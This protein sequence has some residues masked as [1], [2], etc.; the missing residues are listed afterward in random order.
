M[1]PCT[2]KEGGE[3]SGVTGPKTGGAKVTREEMR[4][5]GEGGGGLFSRDR[6]RYRRH[7]RGDTR[8]LLERDSCQSCVVPCIAARPPTTTTT[9]HSSELQAENQV[10]YS[11]LRDK[12]PAGV[13]IKTIYRNYQRT[14]F[15]EFDRIRPIPLFFSSRRWRR[16]RYSPSLRPASSSLFL[17]LI[18]SLT[19]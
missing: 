17:S 16:E 12:V 5:G 6:T 19:H 13:R 4:A 14:R 9:L 3:K 11:E 2:L 18:R 8:S 15:I 7:R 1:N 10:R